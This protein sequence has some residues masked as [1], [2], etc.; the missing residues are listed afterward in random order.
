MPGSTSTAKTSSTPDW[1]SRWATSRPLCTSTT[2]IPQQGFPWHRRRYR[3]GAHSERRGRAGA[4]LLGGGR[5]PAA[6]LF[7][8]QSRSGAPPRLGGES[9]R[10][11]GMH[12]WQPS[13]VRLPKSW[14]LGKSWCQSR[15]R[16]LG[17]GRTS[18]AYAGHSMVP[19][20]AESALPS[21]SA[22]T[23]SSTRSGTS[24]KPN[25]DS[26]GWLAASAKS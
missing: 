4:G 26:V 19:S 25:P 12:A 17:V 6:L 15:E 18:R 3:L 13:G 9:V 21:Q 2:P 22:K 23:R 16:G 24:A 11:S 20:P 5:A 8:S 1:N 7:Q 10:S 14:R